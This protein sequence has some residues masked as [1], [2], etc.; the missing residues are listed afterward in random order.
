MAENQIIKIERTSDRVAN[1]SP[2]AS[3]GFHHVAIKIPNDNVSVSNDGEFIT[4]RCKWD[5]TR[6]NMPSVVN[7]KR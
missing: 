3:G 7:I 6:F 2:K 1:H 5:K 4:I